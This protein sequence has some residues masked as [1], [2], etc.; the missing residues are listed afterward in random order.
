MLNE[1]YMNENKIDIISSILEYIK[2]NVFTK[3]LKYIFNVLEDNKV[4]TTLLEI[5]KEK[6]C[7]L[8][9][10]DIGK[11]ADNSKIIKDIQTAFLKEIKYDDKIYEPK[12][13]SNHKIPGFYNFYKN[14]SDYLTKN[15]TNE[16]LN[17]EKK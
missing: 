11:I 1:N 14:L 12:F 7:K 6:S 8:D 10:S 16:Y 17:K 4:F 13:I 5:N 15:I 3:Y 9:K 2:E